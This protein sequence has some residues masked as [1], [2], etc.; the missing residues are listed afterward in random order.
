MAQ[1]Y[2]AESTRQLIRC[3]REGAT[4]RLAKLPTIIG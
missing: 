3:G 2:L 1:F 4:E